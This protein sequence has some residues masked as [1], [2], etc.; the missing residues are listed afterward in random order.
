[1]AKSSSLYK[2]DGFSQKTFRTFYADKKVA[3]VPDSHEFLF[4]IS[5]KK[6]SF[7]FI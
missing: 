5:G 2:T 3:D 6:K 4:F 1:V 7:C